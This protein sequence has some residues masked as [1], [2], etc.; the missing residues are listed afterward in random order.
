MDKQPDRAVP[1]FQRVTVLWSVIGVLVGVL[2]GVILVFAMSQRRAASESVAN[3]V[4]PAG[5]TTAQPAQRWF[6]WLGDAP[7]VGIPFQSEADCEGGRKS[8]VSGEV[9]A[10]RSTV[11]ELDKQRLNYRQIQMLGYNP[12]DRAKE[13]LEMATRAYCRTQ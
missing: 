4:E 8:F 7:A 13:R 2:L 9:E 3:E 12:Y 6:I 5:N 10:Y 11:A 1:I